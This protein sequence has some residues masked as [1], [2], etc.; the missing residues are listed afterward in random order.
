MGLPLGV[1]VVSVCERINRLDIAIK[2]DVMI[3]LLIVI[4]QILE[5]TTIN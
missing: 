1:K 2:R 3:N 5:Q 4:V